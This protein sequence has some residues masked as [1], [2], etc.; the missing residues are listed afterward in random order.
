[1]SKFNR[2][3]HQN[4]KTIN[5]CFGIAYQSNGILAERNFTTFRLWAFQII[6]GLFITMLS[7]Y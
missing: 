5:A 7:F 4:V 1:M 2:L 6:N 3:L